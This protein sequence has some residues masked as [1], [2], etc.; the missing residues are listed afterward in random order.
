MG[1]LRRRTPTS[2][3][4]LLRLRRGGEGL[5]TKSRV[6]G[7][8]R[9]QRG[10]GAAPLVLLDAPPPFRA[11]GTRRPVRC[12]RGCRLVEVDLADV[13][14]NTAGAARIAALAGRA[15]GG[16]VVRVASPRLVLLPEPELAHAECRDYRPGWRVADR[17]GAPAASRSPRAARRPLQAQALTLAG[18][19]RR[20]RLAGALRP[21]ALRPPRSARRGRG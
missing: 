7:K 2:P 5:I 15:L 8:R 11:R 4:T 3:R 21:T 18:A 9:P 17:A 12:R 6:W 13:D 14:G 16:S 10:R 19:D 1:K 20:L